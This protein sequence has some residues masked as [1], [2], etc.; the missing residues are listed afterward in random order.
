MVRWRYNWS[1]GSVVLFGI[2]HSSCDLGAPTPNSGSSGRRSSQWWSIQRRIACKSNLV[3]RGSW[4]GTLH[5]WVFVEQVWK[6]WEF[7]KVGRLDPED[8]I[9]RLCLAGLWVSCWSYFYIS[10]LGRYSCVCICVGVGKVGR[11]GE[12]WGFFGVKVGN[13]WVCGVLVYILVF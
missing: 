6:L 11:G 7:E 13:W 8:R 3:R 4:W 5:Y 2:N 9:G 1:V 10:L 12:N